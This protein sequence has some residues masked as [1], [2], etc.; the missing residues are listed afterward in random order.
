MP[1]QRH[2]EVGSEYVDGSLKV[3]VRVYAL[4]FLVALAWVIADSIAIGARSFVPVA[5]GAVVGLIIGVVA[6]RMHVLSWDEVSGQVVGRLDSAGA[7]ILVC[8]I[9]FSL[10]R[11]TLLGLW[12]AAPVVGVAGLATLS[13]LMAGQVVGTGRS[14]RR[15]MTLVGPRHAG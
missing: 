7:I 2:P 12:F 1:Q 10:S 14:I 3:R 11:E 5:V 13:G 15:V 6:S 4:I 8:Y 9:V